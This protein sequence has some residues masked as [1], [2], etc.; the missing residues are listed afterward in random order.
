MREIVNGENG[1]ALAGQNHVYAMTELSQEELEGMAFAEGNN[2]D[3]SQSKKRLLDDGRGNSV[4]GINSL[5]KTVG[6]GNGSPTYETQNLAYMDQESLM[7]YQRGGPSVLGQLPVLDTSLGT[8]QPQLA[9]YEPTKWV[10]NERFDSCQICTKLFGIFRRKH[11]CRSCGVL[12][13]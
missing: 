2:P 10:P 3:K 8:Q 6:G 5:R 7:S 13:C 11:H 1:E 4:I 12:V 9:S